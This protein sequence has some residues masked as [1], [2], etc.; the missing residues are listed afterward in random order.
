[1]ENNLVVFAHKIVSEMKDISRWIKEAKERHMGYIHVN[2]L[3]E[4]NESWLSDHGYRISR[5][6]GLC[7]VIWE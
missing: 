6:N 1:M 7:F 3:Y 2:H 5:S 4:D